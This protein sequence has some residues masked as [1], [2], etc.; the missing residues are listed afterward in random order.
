VALVGAA[1]PVMCQQWFLEFEGAPQSSLV[2]LADAQFPTETFGIAVGARETPVS[3]VTRD[4]GRRWQWEPLPDDGVSVHFVSAQEGWLATPSGLWRTRD[5]GI[6]WAAIHKI[7]DLRCVRFSTPDRGWAAGA[8][9]TVIETRDGGE[10]WTP[11]TAASEPSTRAEN[12]VYGW[13]EFATPQAGAIAGWSA[14]P[15]QAA[16][17]RLLPSTSILLDTRN[18]GDL[19]HASVVS[20]FGRIIRVKFSSKG[21][22][23]GLIEFPG[24]FDWPSEV[25]QIDWRTGESSRSFREPDQAVTDL[26]F[27][28]DGTAWLA[29]VET[30]ETPRDPENLGRLRVYRSEDLV[31]WTAAPFA[32]PV[33]ARHALFAVSPAGQIRIATGSGA[34]YRWESRNRLD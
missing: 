6:E 28:P 33:F 12:T 32:K 18:G 24:R 4:G 25:F 30:E 7:A 31:S 34:V 19:W 3:L 15:G 27:G 29:T 20:M 17:S 14:P 13:I 22:G 2:R 5:G 16:S 10:T 8:N 11:L 9:K 23:L 1:G 21:A 26:A